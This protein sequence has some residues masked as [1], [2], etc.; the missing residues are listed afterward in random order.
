V[1]ALAGNPNVGKSTIFNALTGM[2]QHTGNWPGKTVG[3]AYGSFTYN[4]EEIILADI[5]G[6]YSLN[7]RSD[8]EVRA[9]DEVLFGGAQRIVVVCDASNLQ[10]NLILALQIMEVCS[11]VVLCVNLID[12]AEKRGISVD[13]IYLAGA[14]GVPA[15]A[16]CAATG[17]GL[18]ELET[19]MCADTRGKTRHFC[20]GC[21]ITDAAMPLT[22][23]FAKYNDRLPPQW[24]SLQF[25][26]RDEIVI[27]LLC[28]RM[29]IDPFDEEMAEALCESE[30]KL[31][32]IGFDS[33]MLSDFI[34]QHLN[35]RAREICAD[36]V[37]HS[38]AGISSEHRL[39]RVFTHKFFGPL[40]ML[41]L[42][43]LVLWIT[44]SGANY[45]SELIMRALF[46]LGRF[47]HA[48][49]SQLGAPSRL[50]SFL[51]DGVYKT[52][53][54]VVS[55]ML[56]PMAIFF[57]LFTLLEDFGY[58]PRIAF[59]LDGAFKKCG[60]CGKQAL[61][62]CMGF[63]CNAA[64][65]VGCRIIDSPR[66]KIIA[67]VTNSFVPCNGRFPTL[68]AL[69]TIFFAGKSGS[70]VAAVILT[71]VILLGIVLTFAASKL[72]SKT[73]LKGV[74]SSFTLEL[75]PF[76]KP[77]IGQ[78]IVRSVFDRTLF[79]LG[80]AVKAAAP[81]GALI[82]LLGNI[83]FHGSPLLV[84]LSSFFEIPASVFGMDGAII[85]AF[86]FAL[87]ANEI[88]VPM[89]L[90]CYL[91]CGSLVEYSGLAQLHDIL[92]SNGWTGITA[93][94]VIVFTLLHWPCAT[95]LMTIRKETGSMGY[96]LLSAAL[97]T[98]FGLCACLLINL[99]S[100]LV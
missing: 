81:A 96:T 50:A 95:T 5:P 1:I 89:M 32:E 91:S 2:H 11:D 61:T 69:I 72:L 59:N 48:A 93:L 41:A 6:A 37:K 97:P 58:L 99:V 9:L 85:L 8:E 66:E 25:L 22:E 71:F 15:C 4:S 44:I 14:L 47:L 19:L 10:R 36:V 42:L 27:R 67:I 23:Y 56:P 39:D 7:A 73:V 68:I 65:A 80:R 86:I 63:G 84:I 94:C 34:A 100:K 78:V 79:V 82:W 55:V 3:S 31:R 77:R 21:E 40:S 57:P 98:A 74:H 30:D 62:M 18:E 75:P 64:A 26:Q 12:E 88:V 46:A 54:W 13:I 33:K 60:A 24:L 87:P 28:E 51:F 38:E 35:E 20:R 90:M 29:G 17:E 16:V 52:V 83:T 92:I 76:R 70:L 45:P 49:V 43:C 53:A